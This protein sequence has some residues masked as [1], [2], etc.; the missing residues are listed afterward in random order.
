M[1]LSLSWLLLMNIVVL[2]FNLVP[3]FPLDGGRIARAL[4]WRVTGDNAARDPHRG[5]ARPGFAVI[6]AGVGIWLLVSRPRLGGLWLIISR[7]CSASRRGA[8]LVQTALTERIEGV[9]V[10]DIM[11]RQPV[12]IPS[13]T[14]V[15]QALDEYFL[16]Y[17]WSWFPVVDE[18]AASWASAP[19][20]RAG[21][22]DAGEGWLTVGSVLESEEPAGGGSTRT[23]RSPNCSSP[24]RW[25][26]SAR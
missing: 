5:E 7:S 18:K 2:I 14:A 21:A 26:A 9:R 23:D 16:R 3:A 17:G 8:A 20:A 19:G 4:V 6:L 15:S 1:L 10:A 25:A 12:A 13:S 24:S 11:D 22:V